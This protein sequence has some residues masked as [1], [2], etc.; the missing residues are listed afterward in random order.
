MFGR[1][2]G[3]GDFA[4]E[5][6]A[7]LAAEADRLRDE[8]MD[9][10]AARAAAHR[11]F[12]NVARAQERFYESRRW[13]WSDRLR[14][15][16]DFG[17]RTLRKSPGFTAAAVLTLALGLGATSAIFTIVDATLLRPLPYP[18]PDELVAIQD[19][20][21]GV[22]SMDVGMSTPEWKDWQRSGIFESVSPTWYDDNNLTGSSQPA[23]VRLLTVAAN[24]FAVLGVKPGIGRTFNPDDPTPGFNLEVVIS[25]GMWK[26][27]FAADPDVIGR[28][29]TLDTD[30]Y[31]IVGVMPPDFRPPGRTVAERN[32]DVWL[33]AGF[34]ATPFTEP[35]TRASR[36]P[37]AIARLTRGES[38]AEAQHRADAL[39]AR[40]REAYPA[41]YPAKSAWAVHLVPLK[42]RVVG[43]VRDALLLLFGAVA[44]VLLIVYVNLGH[45]L[46][47]RANTRRREMA[48][49]QALGAA[50]T[51]LARQLLTESLLLSLL[52]AIAGLGILFATKGL[53]VRLLPDSLPRPN[54]IAV[55]WR[56]LLFAFGASA[57]AGV[58]FG[59]APA[60]QAGQLD[61]A[62]VL[63]QG[64]RGSAGSRDKAR[65]RRVLVAA[66][67]ALSLVLMIAASLLLRSFRD[68]LNVRL[69][70]DPAG[71]MSVKT[72]LPYPNNPRA[73]RYGTVAQ[74][75]RL[76]REIL[77]RSRTLPGVEEAAMGNSTAIPL[78]HDQQDQNRWSLV[79]EGRASVANQVPL[80]N[81]AIVSPEYFHL[82][83]MALDR[84]RLF[85][86]ADDEQAPPVVV[87]NE[88]MAQTYWPRENAVGQHIRLG[89]VATIWTTIV[90][91]VGDART[92]TLAD[93][94]IPQVFASVY[95]NGAKHAA[96]FVRGHLDLAALPDQVRAQVQA[97][98]PTLPVFDAQMLSDTVAASLAERR[99]S[100]E[101]VAVFAMTA[102]CLATLGI[103]GVTSFLVSA[104]THEIGIRL[105][106][107]AE[108]RSLV[109][110]IVREGAG[111]AVAGTIA[112]LAGAIAAARLMAGVLY[113]L[114]PTDALTFA[115]V[116]LLLVAVA[117]L[118]CYIPARRAVR[119]GPLIA[120]G[121]E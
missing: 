21:P 25:D 72:R 62:Q 90:G 63:K 9:P 41:D 111:L 10:E 97:V 54:A 39:V 65:M 116:A 45:L 92:E 36:F 61:V 109:G 107:G 23:R 44:V 112:G 32:I 71:V 74:Q 43:G 7:H 5:I 13:R 18:H 120:L 58:I 82:L 59:V 81:Q 100:M 19:D 104:R 17:A 69:G 80:V 35:P 66:E 70:F 64:G 77:R 91:V 114:K 101:I 117:V 121:Y 51:R 28:V 115:G 118:A 105:A 108:P 47:A 34:A 83:G 31:R 88:A 110:I 2:R 68:L 56:V 98:D 76:F 93:A 53:L 99:F 60:W 96:I 67:F 50:R 26:R 94:R 75:A 52:G 73:D 87:I 84:G 46:L 6:E 89:R 119:A 20:L 113:G 38:I 103:Y 11:A 27:A 8:G 102:L 14:Q 40:L 48:I 12:G 85:T 16:V 49:R 86:A 33:A 55:D 4:A 106:L 79:I 15:D 30:P 29:I 57:G 24:Y 42:D 22:G 37:E 3:S 78:D 1:R 95:Q